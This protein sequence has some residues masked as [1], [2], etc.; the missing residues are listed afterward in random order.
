MRLLVFA[1]VKKMAPSS[2]EAIGPQVP[3]ELSRGAMVQKSRCMHTLWC[4][5]VSACV[6][7]MRL[8]SSL[9]VVQRST[10]DPE[11]NAECTTNEVAQFFVYCKK[12]T[13]Q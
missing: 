1:A 3:D 7:R 4:L 12:Y 8:C 9:S 6:P 13:F 5:L 2:R 10:C 11:V